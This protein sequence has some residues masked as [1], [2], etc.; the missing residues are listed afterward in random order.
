MGNEAN[1]GN[2]G[3]QGNQGAVGGAGNGGGEQTVILSG[4][5]WRE[6]IPS[7][8]RE[9]PSLKAY[10]DLGGV[11]KSLVNAQRMVGG[12]K[13]VVPKGAL[14]TDETWGQVWSKL[15]RPDSPEG[16]GI[17]KPED[18]PEAYPYDESYDTEFAALAHKI[19]LL[20]KQ[21]QELRNWHLGKTKTDLE[22]VLG[23][24]DAQVAASQ[25][26][27]KKEWGA[28]YDENLNL[29]NRVLAT[30]AAAA[31]PQAM[32]S[33][34]Q[35]Y[36]NDADLA[37]LFYAFGGLISES[38][39][40]KGDKPVYDLSAADARAKADAI[41]TDKSDPL[42][43]AYYSKSHPLHQRAVDEVQRLIAIAHAAGGK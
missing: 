22:K 21:V 14:D 36:G 35:K 39:I 16:Y 29:A 43:E 6:F 11:F 25:D 19:G 18:W 33:I 24:Y 7:D 15:G 3:D 23:D 26:A 34:V 41:M 37:R 5:N 8:L 4:E 31:N 20:P 2:Q 10:Q 40:Q 1:A 12:E 9:E 42:N 32:Q 30:V 28:K 17:K 27:L 13:I 38:S